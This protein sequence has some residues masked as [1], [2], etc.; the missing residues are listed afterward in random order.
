MCGLFGKHKE[1]EKTTDKELSTK[2]EELVT[3]NKKTYEE[4]VKKC[5]K[6]EFN[7]LDDFF[8]GLKNKQIEIQKKNIQKTY[9]VCLT[10]NKGDS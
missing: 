9:E 1:H 5:E 8:V 10:E 3:K 7:S 6:D 2:I 4:L